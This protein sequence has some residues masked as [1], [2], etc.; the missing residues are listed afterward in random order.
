MLKRLRKSN[1]SRKRNPAP[2]GKKKKSKKWPKP[3]IH[4][5][6]TCP[7]CGTFNDNARYSQYRDKMR[8]HMKTC[9]MNPECLVS[10]NH[11]SEMIK[12]N[13]MKTHIFNV[14][15]DAPQHIWDKRPG[16]GKVKIPENPLRQFPL[17]SIFDKHPVS[18]NPG[19]ANS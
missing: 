2:W 7:H 15:R 17:E 3:K 12:I 19:T 4:T 5:P 9:D 11:C 14:C 1:K 8:R 13:E 6:E 18:N 16:R 10:C